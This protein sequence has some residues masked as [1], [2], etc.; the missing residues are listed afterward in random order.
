MLIWA[1]ALT[2]LIGIDW[3]LGEL[4]LV[5][6]AIRTQRW[7]VALWHSLVIVGAI[8]WLRMV[9]PVIWNAP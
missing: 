1:A 2:I 7:F 9:V 5:I 4:A 8:L 6:R 3:I